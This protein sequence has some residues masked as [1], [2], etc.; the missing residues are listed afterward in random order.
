VLT[1]VPGISVGHWSNQEA[2]T[3]VTVVV[4]PPG[5]TAS[6]EVRGGAP[7]T[8]EFALL[9]PLNTVGHVDAVVLSG[10]S[11]FGLAAADGVMTWLDEQGRG[12]A[13]KA[14]PVPI[15]VGLSLFDL[16]VGDGSVRPGPAEGRAA[17]EAATDGPTPVGPVGA[18]TG[19]TVAKW[20]GPDAVSPGGLVAATIRAGDLIVAA[21]VAVNAVGSIDDGTTL[22]DPGPPD[23]ATDELNPGAPVAGGADSAGA[24]V[25]GGADS[26]GAPVAGRENTTIGVVATNA[27]VDKVGCHLL[28]RSAHDGLARAVM[29]AH[30]AGD[31]DTFVAVAT[32][33]VEANAAH[34][35]VLAQ[36]A[37]TRAIR[38]LG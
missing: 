2:R 12:F 7:A 15:V 16:G 38:D 22:S 1:D 18:G 24:P 36:Q 37:V 9:D 25:A 3:G 33:D 26:A 31:G 32:G 23:G 19:A 14:G 17:A 11:A 6:G 10:G 5:T 34:V 27:I 29:P 28:A 35:R 30:T 13:T 20:Y 21:L 4:L 8:R